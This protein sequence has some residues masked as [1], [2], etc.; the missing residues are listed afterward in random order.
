MNVSRNTVYNR[1]VKGS[2]YLNKVLPIL[3]EKLL[4]KELIDVVT[5]AVLPMQELSL[6][7]LRNKARMLMPNTLSRTSEDC[8][9]WKSS[10]D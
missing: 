1:F 5:C 2:E 7:M 4:D 10:T 3:K 6:S 8:M 9:I